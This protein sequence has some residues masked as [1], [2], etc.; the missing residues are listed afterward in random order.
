M[1]AARHTVSQPRFGS[2]EVMRSRLT[3]DS[4][5]PPI[6]E[7]SSMNGIASSMMLAKTS[8]SVRTAV[9]SGRRAMMP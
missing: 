7:P 4:M 5:S 2:S 6:S 1:P 3:K 8:E 9:L